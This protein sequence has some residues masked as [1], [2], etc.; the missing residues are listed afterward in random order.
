MQERHTLAQDRNGQAHDLHLRAFANGGG[1]CSFVLIVVP[2]RLVV[3]FGDVVDDF[4]RVVR[5]AGVL[6]VVVDVG[7]CFQGAVCGFKAIPLQAA[8]NA[9]TNPVCG[10]QQAVLLCG[11]AGVHVVG[12]S[13]QTVAK[14]LVG[15]DGLFA[16]ERAAAAHSIP[17]AVVEGADAS[18]GHIGLNR[19]DTPGIVGDFS[20]I[21]GFTVEVGV[22]INRPDSLQRLLHVAQHMVPH[23]IEPEAGDLVMLSPGNQR[24]DHQLFHH[25][26]LGCRVFTAGGVLNRTRLRVLSVVVAG[27]Q[28]VQHRLVGQP[29]RIGVV[30]D[31]VHHHIQ[32]QV[33]GGLDHFPELEHTLGTCGIGGVAALRHGVMH[34]IVSPVEAVQIPERVV[35]RLGVAAHRIVGSQNGA[36]GLTAFAMGCIFAC[37]LSRQVAQPGEGIVNIDGAGGIFVHRCDVEGR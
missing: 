36:N 11:R 32:A 21:P 7:G 12:V 37:G 17:E 22:R 33:G 19:V 30:V 27:H 20:E 2:Q 8:G 4:L 34:R 10:F 6:T 9:H 1:V 26:V 5:V 16:V 35:E 31:H 18:A 15:A 25:P 28:L 13:E 29:G 24:V 23:Q 3:V 14:T